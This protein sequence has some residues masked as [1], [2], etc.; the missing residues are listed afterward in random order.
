MLE[1]AHG[2]VVGLFYFMA[3]PLTRRQ[4]EALSLAACGYTDVQIARKMAIARSTTGWYLREARR[5]LGA[6]NTTHAVVV[7]I[8]VGLFDLDALF[9]QATGAGCCGPE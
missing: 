6:L 8:A 3:E 2:P 5:K 1:E 7:A 4:K 9:E